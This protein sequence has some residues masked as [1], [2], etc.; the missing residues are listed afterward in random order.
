LGAQPLHIMVD[1][2]F[3]EIQQPLFGGPI[4]GGLSREFHKTGGFAHMLF[5]TVLAVF[6]WRGA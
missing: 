1:V 4:G 5:L 3:V 6:I 2:N